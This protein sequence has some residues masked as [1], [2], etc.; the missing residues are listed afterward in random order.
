MDGLKMENENEIAPKLLD[1]KLPNGL[2]LV[3]VDTSTGMIAWVDG[4][5]YC[6]G[7]SV[8]LDKCAVRYVIPALA[9]IRDMRKREGV[10]NAVD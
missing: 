1:I 10:V 2:F 8:A 7:E 4:L 9:K 5:E 6:L 3:D